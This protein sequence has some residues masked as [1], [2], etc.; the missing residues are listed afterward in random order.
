M[1]KNLWHSPT[2][3]PEITY[4]DVPA[5]IEFL[6]RAFG[7]RER[8]EARLTGKGFARA[9]ME[10]G[11]GLISLSTGEGEDPLRRTAAH[12]V[13]P[14]LRTGWDREISPERIARGA[15]NRFRRRRVVD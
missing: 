4:D 14:Q 6:T 12:G 11:D 15:A 3:V 7:L 9:F 8:V 1:S 2:V 10:L 5:A 13:S